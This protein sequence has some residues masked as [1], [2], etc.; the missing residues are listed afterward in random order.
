MD[1]T[2]IHMPG[3]GERDWPAD[4]MM[5]AVHD[6]G[7]RARYRSVDEEG[8]QHAV[9]EACSLV[10]VAGGDGTVE[11][12]ACALRGRSAT[13]AILPIGGSN[14]IARSFGAYYR[15]EQILGRLHAARRKPLHLCEAQGANGL[16]C[17]VESIGIG[18][19]ARSSMRLP[20]ER[21]RTEKRDRGR[22]ALRDE[23][24]ETP[25]ARARVIVD[26]EPLPDEALL[27][28]VMNVAMIGPNL[29]LVP[30]WDPESP[31]LTVTWLPVSGRQA[32]LDWLA[33]SDGRA[34]PLRRRPA[35]HVLFE[36]EDDHLHVADEFLPEVRG[37]VAIA[38]DGTTLQLLVP[39][40]LS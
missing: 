16:H 38:R 9:N 15:P 34:P 31:H 4:R 25:P 10:V 11:R 21:T 20:N 2:L 17:F 14:N 6:A 8:W 32:M 1:V 28:E 5:A 24:H 7:L 18:A 40:G 39:E 23:L 12:V 3:A 33:E 26:G 19:L 37:P 13:L 29:R 30:G 36:L 27:V 22:A 35:R